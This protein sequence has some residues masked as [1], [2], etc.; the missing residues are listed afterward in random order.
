MSHCYVFPDPNAQANA[1]AQ[2][3]ADELA[4]LRRERDALE[5][6]L[7][8]IADYCAEH[9]EDWAITAEHARQVIAIASGEPYALDDEG[10]K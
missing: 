8:W 5:A 9:R 3:I 1:T 10:L 4:H 6:R 7:H 2:V